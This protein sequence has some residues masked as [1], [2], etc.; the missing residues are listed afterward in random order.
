MAEQKDE[1][2][3]INFCKIETTVT[4]DEDTYEITEKETIT[5]TTR[6]CIVYNI[7]RNIGIEY[8]DDG[9]NKIQLADEFKLNAYKYTEKIEDKSIVKIGVYA[10]E[11]EN[12]IYEDLWYIKLSVKSENQTEYIYVNFI[13]NMNKSLLDST[14]KNINNI[15]E[16]TNPGA[17]ITSNF[18]TFFDTDNIFKII[19]NIASQ[20]GIYK[21]ILQDDAEFPCN[22]DL[23]YG[24]KAVQLRAL[25][26]NTDLDQNTWYSRQK[27]DNEGKPIG[28]SKL[29]IYQKSGFTPVKYKTTPIT[30]CIQALQKV[31]CGKL[32]NVVNQLKK[33]LT[34]INEK[35]ITYDI[36]KMRINEE[37]DNLKIEYTEVK[38]INYSSICRDYHKNLDL[39]YTTFIK[40]GTNMTIH[41]YYESVC[42]EKKEEPTCCNI[43]GD[44]LGYLRNSINSHVIIIKGIKN[45]EV[46]E[47]DNK[48]CYGE[49]TQ[50]MKE[51]LK[52]KNTNNPLVL[53]T[54]SASHTLLTTVPTSLPMRR[55]SS[56]PHTITEPND[57]I[58]VTK[59]F[60]LFY[61]TFEK[62]KYIFFKMELNLPKNEGAVAALP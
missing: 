34:R 54:R 10:T 62:L 22:N 8:T 25:M 4:M 61:G 44:I 51:K 15:N 40:A 5:Q 60:N 11:Q 3:D 32:L 38:P 28:K 27:I 18:K 21:I 43:R 58:I 2:K 6:G 33:L 12:I 53:P 17:K 56:G 29:S 37:N 50:E 52:I 9:K 31:T 13:R 26:L 23:R 39:L 24:I 46:Q 1:N 7:P 57:P 36:Y 19:K 47:Q 35:D 16:T 30:G 14:L 59:L 55:A 49:I 42:K 41:Q 48:D 20:L 45:E